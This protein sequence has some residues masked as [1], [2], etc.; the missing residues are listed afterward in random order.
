MAKIKTK[1]KARQSFKFKN[2]KSKKAI[3]SVSIIKVQK[4][5]LTS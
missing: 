3:N 2:I 1:G 4:V 5:Q